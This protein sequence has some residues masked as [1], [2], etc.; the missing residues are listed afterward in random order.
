MRKLSTEQRAAILNCLIEGMSIRATC[1]LTGAAKVTVLRLLADAGRVCVEHHDRT[2]RDLATQRIQADEAWGFVGC[3]DKAKKRGAQGY[4][5][6]WTWVAQD[7]DSKVVISWLVGDR[8][9]GHANV[10]MD[11]VADRV[12][13]RVQ[14]ST[15]A[16]SAYHEAVIGAF[17]NEDTGE[18]RAD[19]ATVSKVYAAAPKEEARRYSPAVCIGCEKTTVLGTPDED[20]ISTSY[21]ERQNRDL[22]M[23]CRRMT[24]LTDAFSKKTENHASATALHYWA[25][26]FVK[27]HATLKR[28]PA[29]AAG[30]ASRPLTT[31]DLAEMIESEEAKNGGRRITSYLA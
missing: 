19:F 31:F 26:N 13:G 20:E 1:R 25:F 10:F 11:D 9:A 30:I 7:A 28:T 14:I 23:R 12:P 6:A 5:S 2:V 17:T 27:K 15:D 21:I 4:G 24:R 22:R 8:D 29:M 3:K 18:I 16:L